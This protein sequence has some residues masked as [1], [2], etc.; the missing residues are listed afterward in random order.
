MAKALKVPLAQKKNELLFETKLDEMGI[1][2]PE[3]QALFKDLS[4]MPKMRKSR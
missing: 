2:E 1:K 4:K 3:L